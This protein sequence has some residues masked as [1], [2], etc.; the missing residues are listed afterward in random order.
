MAAQQP[1]RNNNSRENVTT[2]TDLTSYD[3]YFSSLSYKLFN[4]ASMIELS[5]ID[6]AFIG[7]QPKKGEKVYDH[8]NRLSVFVTANTAF[9]LKSGIKQLRESI[10]NEEEDDE[11]KLKSVSVDFGNATTGVRKITVFAPGRVV[12]KAGGKKAPVEDQFVVT[13]LVEKDGEK[14]TAV[15]A[16][17]NSELTYSFTKDSANDSVTDV[18]NV[19]LEL[20]LAFLDSVI[21]NATG[22]VKH[23][24]SSVPR[25]AGGA[26][27]PR[28]QNQFDAAIDDEDED[29]AGETTQTSSR[30]KVNKP[31]AT[32]ALDAEF[33]EDV[34]Q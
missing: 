19:G 11:D 24:A 29:D 4:G 15:H 26:S 31:A 12:V 2:F 32:K 17:Q 14:I 7:K 18:V 3:S 23:G 20:F 6:P 25:S 10:A 28:R 34:P 21:I 1:T 27:A 22:L 16:L 13:F 30:G 5:S 33:D 8:D 9:L